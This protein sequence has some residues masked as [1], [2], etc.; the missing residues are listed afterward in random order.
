VPPAGLGPDPDL[1]VVPGHLPQNTRDHDERMVECDAEKPD[2]GLTLRTHIR[3]IVDLAA[4]HAYPR[5]EPEVE[6]TIAEHHGGDERVVAAVVKIE[7]FRDDAGRQ[8]TGEEARLDPVSNDR[9]VIEL[10]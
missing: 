3:S 2:S 9:E 5:A 6:V 10:G 8:V 7:H 1:G 4:G